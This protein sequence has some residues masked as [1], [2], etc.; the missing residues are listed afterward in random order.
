LIDLKIKLLH[1]L[2]LLLIP[3]SAALGQN[4]YIQHYTT[5]DG[6]PTNTIY[7]LFQD[8][9]N[10]IWMATDAGVVRYN[11][12]K[13]EN[14]TKKDGLSSNE[15]IRI[16]EDSFERI[17]LINLNGTTNYYCA[18]KFFNE[19]KA[20]FLDSLKGKEFFTDCIEGTDRTVYFINRI[21]EIFALNKKNQIN[22]YCLDLQC[23][24]PD[25]A[26]RKSENY[27]ND[28]LI[29]T[30]RGLTSASKKG[31]LCW[32]SLGLFYIPELKNAHPKLLD[33]V[34]CTIL[35]NSKYNNCN[36]IYVKI[37]H[38][39]SSLLHKYRHETR[40]QTVQMPVRTD[41][42]KIYGVL[43]DR[44][45]FLW[46]ATY[47]DGV[48]CMR[49]NKV[50]QRID[51]KQTQSMLLDHEGNIWI[52]TMKN[53]LYKINPY[54]VLHK[55]LDSRQFEGKGI[56]ALC[57]DPVAGVWFSNGS[58]IY[59]MV[60][61]QLSI[62]DPE[63]DDISLTQV[64]KLKNGNLI[65]GE[66]DNEYYLF[67][68]VHPTHNPNKISFLKR[69]HFPNKI[70]GYSGFK[71]RII[72]NRKED[73]IFTYWGSGVLI[74]NQQNPLFV[75]TVYDIG[76]KVFNA[77]FNSR[78]DIIIN[79]KRNYI[80]HGCTLSICKNLQ[81]IDNKII[82]NHLIINDSV[83]L[84]NVE[85]ERIYLFYR[86]KLYP[87][88]EKSGFLTNC[89]VRKI[90][91]YQSKLFIATSTNIFICD[92]PTRILR[93]E[94]VSLQS[95]D[96]TFKN[97]Q[98]IL[99]AGDSLYVAN[100]DGL[101]ILP[102]K[103]NSNGDI[104]KPVPY[105]QSVLANDSMVIFAG[106][107]LQMKNNQRLQIKYGA[108][109]YS[110]APLHF[111]YRLSDIN[112][113]WVSGAGTE[114]IFQ[115]LSVGTYTFYL[116]ARKSNSPWS[117]PVRLLI[118]VDAVFWQH[119]LFLT[120]LFLLVSGAVIFLIFRQKNIKLRKQKMSYQLVM[121]EQ[122][123]LQS[124]MNPHFLF[125]ALSSIQSYLLMNKPGEAG[126]YLSQFARLIRQNLNAINEAKINIDDE[127][128][129]LK[130]YLDLEKMRM[131]GKFDYQI[132]VKDNFDDEE[133]MLPSMIIQPFVENSIWHGIAGIED[134]GLIRIVFS[135]KSEKE[136]IVRIE[137]NGVGFQK[138]TNALQKDGKRFHLGVEMTRKRLEIL[139]KKFGIK[140]ALTFSENSPGSLN[141]GTVVEIVI[142]VMGSGAE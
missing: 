4:P 95:I 2:Y 36:Y 12:S 87:F 56:T 62:L 106:Q 129:R 137:D 3:A 111:S 142:P 115:N 49:N 75:D 96:I 52:S 101:T 63:N 43:E 41:R 53:G 141:P 66:K 54:L 27:L 91:Y 35:F 72:A 60:D 121:L 33:S 1:C 48:F 18:D 132:E 82:V 93:N 127:I 128:D 32:T 37:C 59:Y 47:N 130:N 90:E 21:G 79:A 29:F 97:I 81:E 39:D 69:H 83:E 71:K 38:D 92:E 13:F 98:D 46:V 14:F 105:I 30:F 64:S 74:L 44:L 84:L 24:V 68:N 126:L 135:Q 11:G 6:L 117:E 8:S 17:W 22:K 15:V 80:V 140:T 119:P 124:M 139:G 67:E 26:K 102:V 133:I 100:D 108:I 104:S 20:P 103:R 5:S 125:N 7:H 136:I 42:G 107:E 110:G 34:V 51:I 50:I 10:F 99:C 73:K 77:Y 23:F 78:D 55:H 122:K 113:D 76:T 45:G 88:Q 28:K 85:G 58:M 86:N 138:L 120:L 109:S 94:G 61:N 131:G 40:L 89:Q 16:F 118:H 114:V 134:Q 19:K 25:Q 116:R 70:G 123:A 31:F 65:A 57:K 9:K 112:S